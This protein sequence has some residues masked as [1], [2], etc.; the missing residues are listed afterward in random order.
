MSTHDLSPMGSRREPPVR[1]LLEDPIMRL[2]WRRDRLCAEQVATVLE[3]ARRRTSCFDGQGYRRQTEG[4]QG[5]DGLDGREQ[6]G[7]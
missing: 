3:G 6:G 7:G 4:R 1:E 2:L 5:H